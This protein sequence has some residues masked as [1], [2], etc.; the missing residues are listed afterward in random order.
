MRYTV[1]EMHVSLWWEIDQW[2]TNK[3]SA[4]WYNF[5]HT[6]KNTWCRKICY[7]AY[8]LF[9]HISSTHVDTGS[10]ILSWAISSYNQ[11]A[12]SWLIS[13]NVWPYSI[14]VNIIRCIQIGDLWV[15]FSQFHRWVWSF[16]IYVFWTA[17]DH[18]EI[19]QPANL[20]L[21]TNAL[22]GRSLVKM[23]LIERQN[24]QSCNLLSYFECTCAGKLVAPA[25]MVYKKTRIV[26]F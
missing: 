16:P 22:S 14:L 4:K 12:I 3:C 18:S 17:S 23:C 1:H 11:A 13:C 24:S 2:N 9:V 7:D 21:L 5:L 25:H 19:S 15:I 10:Q 26:F 20:P 6:S 8:P